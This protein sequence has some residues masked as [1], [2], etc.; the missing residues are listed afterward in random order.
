MKIVVSVYE[1]STETQMIIDNMRRSKAPVLIGDPN[2]PMAVLLS[3]E[4]YDRLLRD[5]HKS[6][7]VEATQPVAQPEPVEAVAAP[8]PDG[9]VSR[10]P[11]PV[12][13]VPA[14]RHS[15]IAQRTAAAIHADRAPAAEPPVVSQRQNAMQPDPTL[16][17]MKR[18]AEP[19][20]APRL[21][22]P[23]PKPPRPLDTPKP[24]MQFNL[25][26]IPGGWQ[27]VALVLGMLALG[28]FGFVL[29]V[30]AFNG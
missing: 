8:K 2:K 29:I 3:L 5:S 26:A 28:I 13:V 6:V 7:A 15:D 25:S 18:V 21:T 17:T 10:Q 20:R 24:R 1:L 23:L 14:N 19:P 22:K 11:A 12:E 27:T 30:S 16:A 9:D 4:E